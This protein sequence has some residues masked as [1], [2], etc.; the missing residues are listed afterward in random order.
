MGKLTRLRSGFAGDR[1]GQGTGVEGAEDEGDES[2]FGEY[3]YREC[4]EKEQRIMVP[5][6][7]FFFFGGRRT[8]D[9]CTA[10]E[11]ARKHTSTVL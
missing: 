5:G 3:D 11:G 1:N 10:A 8:G 4:R 6:L 7:R 2:G 9:S